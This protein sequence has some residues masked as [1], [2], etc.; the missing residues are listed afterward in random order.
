MALRAEARGLSGLFA[1]DHLWMPGFPGTPA[2]SV[3]PLLGAV[4]TATKG[5]MVGPLVARIGLVP[6]RVLVAEVSTLSLIAPGRVVAGLGAGDTAGRAEHHAHGITVAPLD[7]RLASLGICCEEMLGLGLPVWVGARSESTIILARRLGAAVNLW[8]ATPGEV[9]SEA[10][11]GEVTW[12]GPVGRGSDRIYRVLRDLASAGASWA[13]CLRPDDRP[14][15]AGPA[16]G[17]TTRLED[18]RFVD[19]VA[20]AANRLR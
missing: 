9:R 2:F 15:K 5:L 18:L 20:N 16:L 6:D 1:Y 19:E 7:I 8:K 4:A 14:R 12:A 10:L 11:R 17:S 13:V 3:F